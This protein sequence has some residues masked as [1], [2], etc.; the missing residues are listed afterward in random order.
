MCFIC[1]NISERSSKKFVKLWPPSKNSITRLTQCQ[2]VTKKE[3][4]SL[5]TSKSKVEQNNQNKIACDKCRKL[6]S[7]KSGLKL[8]V[9]GIHEG[10]KPYACD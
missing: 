9:S 1:E 7:K 4:K 2:L 3:L 8:H 6:F 5:E 10:L